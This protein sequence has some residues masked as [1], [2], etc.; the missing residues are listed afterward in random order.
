MGYQ[1]IL[2]YTSVES[3]NRFTLA[4]MGILSGLA[5]FRVTRDFVEAYEQEDGVKA[6]FKKIRKRLIAVV[7]ALTVTSIIAFMK[8]FYE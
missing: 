1:E 6:A 8:R 3:V 2:M 4:F 7:I 5:V